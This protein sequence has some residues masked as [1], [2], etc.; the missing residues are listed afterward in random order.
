MVWK[1]VDTTEKSSEYFVEE[2]KKSSYIYPFIPKHQLTQEMCD[3]VFEGDPLVFNY[4]PEEF[5]QRHM[6]IKFVQ[7]SPH[8]LGLVPM[9]L[10]DAEVCLQAIKRA[11]SAYHFVPAKFKSHDMEVIAQRTLKNASVHT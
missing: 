1:K 5:M 4:L 3:I 2:L 9:F 8:S 10:R 11:G 6:A 7:E